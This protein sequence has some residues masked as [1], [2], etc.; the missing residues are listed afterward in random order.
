MGKQGGI[1]FKFEFCS[2]N[3]S[4]LVQS[5]NTCKMCDLKIFFWE[6]GLYLI[7]GFYPR[8]KKQFTDI[9]C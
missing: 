1:H 2:P 5:F 9:P 6:G 4:K 3:T 8:S 7:D